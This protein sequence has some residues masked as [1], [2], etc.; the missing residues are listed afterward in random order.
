MAVATALAEALGLDP[1]T[2]KLSSYGGSGF[3]ASFKLT[4]V[5][6]GKESAFF[7]KTGRGREAEIMFRGKPPPP[8][9]PG[10]AK[11]QPSLTLSQENMPP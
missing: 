5:R 1:S 10:G 8:P 2:A 6:D 3:A 4:G 9:P 11:P 7:V